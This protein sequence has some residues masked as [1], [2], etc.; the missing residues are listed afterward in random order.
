MSSHCKDFISK[1][2]AKNPKERLGAKDDIKEVAA[3]PWF[4]DLDM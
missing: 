1:C 3:H 4:A 2:L